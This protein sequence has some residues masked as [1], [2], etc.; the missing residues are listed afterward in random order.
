MRGSVRGSVVV[1]ES[2]TPVA[3][4][5]IEVVRSGGGYSPPLSLTDA[6]GSFQVD[7]LPAGDWIFKALGPSGEAGDARAPVFDN[8]VSA[9]TVEVTQSPSSSATGQETWL[10]RGRVIR[11]DGKPVPNA[12]VTMVNQDGL[13]QQDLA[14]VTDSSGTFVLDAVPPG[15]WVLHAFTPA[16]ETG[17]A[18]VED[19][20]DVLSDVTIHVGPPPG[21]SR[22]VA[23]EP[24]RWEQDMPGSVRG[25]VTRGKTGEPVT[26]ASISVVRGAGPAPDISPVTDAHGV[27]ALDGLPPGEWV[28][29]AFAPDGAKG[30]VTVQVTSGTVA[31][32]TINLRR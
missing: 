10:V 7:G 30:E 23:R 4:A 15:R 18:T 17:S 31:N 32:A 16:Q 27:F 13:P 12:S 2:G 29:A 11:G 9:V 19:A 5:A 22:R 14:V 20:D 24:T 25:R 28:L 8:A 26:D 21:R 6:F 3:D 1:Q